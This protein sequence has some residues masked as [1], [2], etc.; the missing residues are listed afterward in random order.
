MLSECFHPFS[1]FENQWGFI[2]LSFFFS[3]PFFS[4]FPLF[5]FFL[6]TTL[7]NSQSIVRA[8]LLFSWVQGHFPDG[9]FIANWEFDWQ[10]KLCHFLA[11]LADDLE[12]KSLIH[13]RQDIALYTSVTW[14]GCFPWSLVCGDSF[15]PLVCQCPRKAESLVPNLSVGVP[16]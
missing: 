6:V 15:S 5:F 8:S 1:L 9:I 13:C 10:E 16:L 4:S 12:E 14:K 2:L 3:F 7:L 11:S